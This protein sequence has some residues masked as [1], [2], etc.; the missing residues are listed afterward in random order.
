MAISDKASVLQIN[1]FRSHLKETIHLALPVIVGQF[2]IILMGVVDNILVGR[3][4]YNP[5]A[6]SALANG[7]FFLIFVIGMGV[8]Y[9][10][11]PLVANALGKGNPELC[12]DILKQALTVNIV[13]GVILGTVTYFAAELFQFMNQPDKVVEYAIS[14]LHILAFSIPMMMVFLTYKHF[15]E[16]L[17]IMRP[18]MVIVLAANLVNVFGNYSLIYGNFGFP[19]LELNGAGLSTLFSRLFMMVMLILFLNRNSRVKKY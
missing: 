7:I 6:A 3:I 5:L 16:G 1:S 18:A 2:G 4:G 19:R 12:G 13:I 8:T 15:L 9:A 11:S 14:Y 10:V 17:S